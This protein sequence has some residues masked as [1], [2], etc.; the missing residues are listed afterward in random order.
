[1]SFH[2][3]L[4][5]LPML[6]IVAMLC[7]VVRVGEVAVGIHSGLA[8]AQQEDAAQKS[9][10][11]N[12]TATEQAGA[13]AAESKDLAVE[14]A[15]TS[16][17]DAQATSETPKLDAATGAA[18]TS[19]SISK[20]RDSSEEDYQYSDV[21]AELFRDLSKRREDIESKE[22]ALAAREALLLTAE[23]ELDA[24]MRELNTLR[25]EIEGLLDKQSE[26]EKQRIASLVKIY[27]GMKAKDAARI[28][29]TLDMDVLISVM[30]AMSERKSAPI[31]AEMSSE[32][33]RNVTILLAEQAKLPELSPE[34]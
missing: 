1:M 23:R 15:D 30:V 16:E 25:S 8:Y 17:E 28:F 32:R 31:L 3:K 5:I 13:T 27:E 6:V 19:S 21:R 34:Q 20:W 22:K 33:A 14:D 24:K 12:A 7:L 18:D 9:E 26:E 4:R 10:A 2:Q 11:E 29:N